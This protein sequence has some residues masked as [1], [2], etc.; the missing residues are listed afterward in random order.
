MEESDITHG[1]MDNLTEDAIDTINVVI[2]DYGNMAP[3]ELRELSHNE[4]PWITARNG[5]PEGAGCNTVIE[6]NDMG[7]YYGGL[8]MGG[9]QVG[10]RI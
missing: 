10:G 3:F 8:L 4:E 1:S 5:L 6:K 2:E 9:K 7:K